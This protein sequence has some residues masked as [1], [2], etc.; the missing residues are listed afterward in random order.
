MFEGETETVVEEDASSTYLTFD[1]SEQIL[2]VEVR[3]VREILDMQRIT[4]L[5]NAP[6]DV[7]GVVDVRGASVPVVDLKARLGI[8]AID[9]S[10]D[11]RIV[12]IDFADAS[13][14]PFGILADRVRN[15]DQI[16]GDEIEPCPGIGAGHWDS[17]SLKGLSRRGSDLVV[18]IRLDRIFAAAPGLT[19]PAFRF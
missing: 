10:P 7:L 2:G 18:L 6:H 17:S 3:H 14:S 9:D 12:V 8:P 19:D 11:A 15:V 16:P 1:L 13:H 4:R 5:P